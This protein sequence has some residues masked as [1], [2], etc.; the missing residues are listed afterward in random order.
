LAF[1]SAVLSR[2]VG[3]ISGVGVGVT[4]LATVVSGGVT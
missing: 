3:A 4:A 1:I 2:G